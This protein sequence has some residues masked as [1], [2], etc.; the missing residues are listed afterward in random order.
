MGIDKL[1]KKDFSNENT[2][3]ERVDDNFV[4]FLFSSKGHNKRLDIQV[5]ANGGDNDRISINLKDFAKNINDLGIKSIRFN[6]KREA[7]ASLVKIDMAQEMLVEGRSK[8]AATV[9]RLQSTA[10][11]L[12][13]DVENHEASKSRIL[14]ADYAKET[15]KSVQNNVLA[16]ARTA[17]MSQV[18]SHGKNYLKQLE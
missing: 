9:K 5:D 17:V 18:S 1:L 11:K 10:N 15:A 2:G 3:G 13:I 4:Q 16:N 14:D 8:L 7:Q 12:S 6:T